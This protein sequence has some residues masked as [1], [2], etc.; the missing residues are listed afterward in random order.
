MR[1]E[2][3]QR[4][5][6]PDAAPRPR[7][8]REGPGIGHITYVFPE[9][10]LGN[11]ELRRRFEFKPDF[12][13]VKL[14]IDRR[15]R[16]RWGDTTSDMC[17]AAVDQLLTEAGEGPEAI[18]ALIVVTLNPDY[19]MPHTAALVQQKCGL[20]KRVASFDVA[21]GCSGYVYGLSLADSMMR[22]DGFS[23]VV[24]VTAVNF[25]RITDPNSRATVPI[26]GDAATAT[27]LTTDNPRY[28]LGR[29]TYGTDGSMAEAIIVRGSGT[30]G[31][32]DGLLEMDGRG[33]FNFMM[34]EVPPDVERCLELNGLEKDDVTLWVFHQ[35]SKYMVETLAGRLGIPPERVIL[36]LQD[37]GNT[38]SCTIPLTLRRR[39]LDSEN[40]PEIIGL[41]GFGV[42]ASWASSFLFKN[43]RED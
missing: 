25:S 43:P 18:D 29:C 33:V 35:A 40:L 14:G 23:R 5:S 30:A 17:A 8:R 6:S 1:G 11:E 26:F 3:R 32:G 39:V 20:A 10:T 4:A 41:S 16:A 27:L 42:G 13:E 12:L 21:L 2:K 37:G 31:E 36:D 19:I 24:L 9:D 38:S 7:A 15:Y 34:R 22:S 28:F